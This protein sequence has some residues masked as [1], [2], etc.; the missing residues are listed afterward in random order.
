MAPA[1]A[2]DLVARL[3]AGGQTVAVA[4]SLTGGLVAAELTEVPGASVVV[5]GGVLAYAT[6]LKAA[7][8]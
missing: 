2:A 5:R 4:E 1:A 7:V 3:T 8:L 6:D